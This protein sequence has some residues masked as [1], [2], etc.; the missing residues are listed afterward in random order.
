MTCR[1]DNCNYGDGKLAKIV[2]NLDEAVSLASSQKVAEFKKNEEQEK[3][4]KDL[5]AKKLL[6]QQEQQRKILDADRSQ[7]K[8]Y[9]G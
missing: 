5:E 7:K 1:I 8:N 6:A 2:Y 3:I 9:R 4:I